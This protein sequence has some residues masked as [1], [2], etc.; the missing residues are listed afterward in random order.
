MIERTYL[1]NLDRGCANAD[2]QR[3]GYQQIKALEAEINRLL[4]AAEKGE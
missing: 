3:M 2:E 4:K 1:V